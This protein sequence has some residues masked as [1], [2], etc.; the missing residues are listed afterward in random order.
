MSCQ[1]PPTLALSSTVVCSPRAAVSRY[2]NEEVRTFMAMGR[3]SSVLCLIV[4]GEPNASDLPQTAGLE[5][6]PPA[7]RFEI[8]T[9]GQL[10]NKRVDP[11]AADAREGRDGRFNASLKII[12]G[13]LEVGFDDLR[14]R[15][16]I[17][18]VRRRITIGVAAAAGLAA[19]VLSYILMA[20]GGVLVPAGEAIQLTLDRNGASV[21]RAP[22]SEV[23]IAAEASQ[24][25]TLLATQILDK[26]EQG[27]FRWGSDNYDMWITAQALASILYAPDLDRS[28]LKRAVATWQTAFESVP[29]VTAGDVKFGWR[30]FGLDHTQSESI[31]WATSAIALALERPALLAE[32]ER[33]RYQKWSDEVASMA[34]VYY[35]VNDGGWNMLPRQTDPS[36]HSHYSSVLA[37]QALLDMRRASL[38]WRGSVEKRD[39]LI[40]RTIEWLVK[41]HT[42]NPGG[43]GWL[44]YRL[45]S[46]SI[47]LEGLA[48][49][50]YATLFRA[51]QEVGTLIPRDYRN[52]VY[53]YLVRMPGRP[54][55]PSRAAGTFHISFVPSDG[56]PKTIYSPVNFLWY[57][58]AIECAMRWLATA[59]QHR[60]PAERVTRVRRALGYLVIDLRDEVIRETEKETPW[61]SAEILIALSV[62]RAGNAPGNSRIVTK[63]GK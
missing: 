45:K 4:D 30:V 34:D 55:N 25:R 62:I 49:Q 56:A 61:M 32:T 53:E 3:S 33:A 14:Q 63:A 18:A 8:G 24:L 28:L 37:L 57:P 40:A 58:W 12:S 1:A 7:T 2:V 41:E 17:R 48:L 19:I 60:E 5:C 51:A 42:L 23:R 6:F 29:V 35:P 39:A 59:E 27:Q 52:H 38:P 13:L 46:A 9:D 31:F 54:F 21:L 50:I 16:R 43:S 26:G 47:P 11:M 22:H 20:D 36:L 10:T 44:G 15:E